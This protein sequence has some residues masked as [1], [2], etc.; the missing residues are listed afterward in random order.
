[1]IIC[2][3]HSFQ[4]C[5][6]NW[7]DWSFKLNMDH[8]L[9]SW[10]CTRPDGSNL[11]NREC[12]FRLQNLLIPCC[13]IHL[14]KVS[15]GH[16]QTMSSLWWREMI[17]KADILSLWEGCFTNFELPIGLWTQALGN[18]LCVYVLA[19][20]EGVANAFCHLAN[21]HAKVYICITWDN[22]ELLLS[23][24]LKN[25]SHLPR[26]ES[27]MSSQGLSVTPKLNQ[28]SCPSEGNVYKQN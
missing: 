1:M 13:S 16:I 9:K 14:T 10:L 4:W 20:S 6:N 17:P 8:I 18:L 12:S 25:R 28:N 26:E 2:H 22:H 21:L 15:L 24:F 3:G 27:S 19:K 11:G 5:Y 23:F 7:I